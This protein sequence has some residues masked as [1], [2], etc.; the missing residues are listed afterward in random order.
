LGD[1]LW[2]LTVH[3]NVPRE[4]L[5]RVSAYDWFGSW[6]S[7]RSVW[8]SGDRSPPSSASAASLWVAFALRLAGA[9]ALLAVPEILRLPAAPA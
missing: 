8:R 5:S 9:P 4:S 2:E 1:T 7:T 6:C 3:R